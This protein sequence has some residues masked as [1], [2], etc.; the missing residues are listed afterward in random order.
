V[1]DLHVGVVRG[2]FADARNPADAREEAEQLFANLTAILA[3]V[4]M[5]LI[6]VMRVDIVMRYRPRA[7]IWPPHGLHAISTQSGLAR[8]ISNE[9]T[10]V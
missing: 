10:R 3:A 1:G 5:G 2:R 6:A 7:S 8:R 9:V 4:G